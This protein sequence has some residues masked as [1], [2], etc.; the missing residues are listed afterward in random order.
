M[1]GHS[2]TK[3]PERRSVNTPDVLTGTITGGDALK[4]L[5]AAM[6]LPGE[7]ALVGRVRGAR[8]KG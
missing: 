3:R 5:L 6:V 7:W 4:L 2:A 1:G 8:P